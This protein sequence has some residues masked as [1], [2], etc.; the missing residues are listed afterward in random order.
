M[1]IL[2]TG[3]NGQVGSELINLGKDYGMHML[4]VDLAE[5]DITQS[6]NVK[7]Y[8]SSAQPDIIINAAAHTAVDKAESEVDLAYAINRDGVENLAKVCA[9]QKILLIHI[10]TDYVFNGE[11]KTPYKET[12][13]PNPES[14][15]GQSKLEGEQAVTTLLEQYYILR[16]AWVFGA[17]G[18]NFVKTML[19]LGSE[20][21]ELSIVADQKGA[22]TSARDIAKT[23]LMI[24]QRY[25][26]KQAID[27]GIYH[28]IGTPSAT[29]YHFAKVIFETAVKLKMLKK[30]PKLNA[31]TTED[32]P[33]P[34]KR[35]KNSVLD[36]S[37]IKQ[38][39]NINQ[40]DWTA[41]LSKVLTLWKNQ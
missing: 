9:E 21:D 12:D 24:A 5:L 28:Y 11:N 23:L 29:W 15:Y 37:K 30:I 35:P 18:N 8:I 2:V 14:V 1:K 13:T 20:R 19:R 27:W 7:K 34:A 31:I 6:E 32:Y 25:K 38:A 16:V 17:N 36:C 4:A 40:P 3:A 39:L 41:E 33:T 26:N 10:S 22:P